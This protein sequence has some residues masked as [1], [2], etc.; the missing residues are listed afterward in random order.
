MPG[1]KIWPSPKVVVIGGG[2]GTSTILYGLKQYTDDI[3]AI[4][5]V[6]DNGGSTG[7]LR[8]DL[9]IIATGD[10]RSCLVALSDKKDLLGE[11]LMYRFDSGELDGHNF[12]NLFIAAMNAITKDFA[13]AIT[14]TSKL[15]NITGKVLPITLE[16]ANLV[17]KLENGK[18]VNGEA[19][20]PEV[21]HREKSK[22]EKIYTNPSSIKMLDEAKTHLLQADII[23][24]GPGSLYTSIIPNLLA[25]DMI[26]L[27]TSS[28][29]KTV[30]ISNIMDQFGETEFYSI[31]QHYDAIIKHSK[32]GIIDYI[33]I[34]D[35]EIDYEIL[36]KYSKTFSNKIEFSEEDR[37]YF[38]D[39]NI[40]VILSNLVKIENGLIRH[41]AF[42]LAELIFDKIY[43]Q[44][45]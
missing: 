31:R 13:K 30:Y 15:L 10:L 36:K 34:N 37:K 21:S 22:I 1:T 14:E 39:N 4:I 5:S 7:R 41:D 23:I 8:K 40:E 11:L 20:I 9:D 17:A 24:L 45:K 6:Y 35:G 42:K 12:G 28:K 19:E 25:D 43:F 38:L 33:I 26:D 32:P 18:L 27:I 29:A 3:T 16:N 44:N 2:T